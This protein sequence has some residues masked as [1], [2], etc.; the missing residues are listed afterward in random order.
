MQYIGDASGLSG[1]I[2]HICEERAMV[3]RPAFNDRL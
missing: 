2:R 3:P 1:Q